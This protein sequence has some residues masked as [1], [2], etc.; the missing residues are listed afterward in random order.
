MD[1]SS[2]YQDSLQISS[3]TPLEQ[4]YAWEI[5]HKRYDH[6]PLMTVQE[7][8][9]VQDMFLSN[10]ERG[11]H[12]KNLYLRD[13]KNKN[14]LFIAEQ[15]TKIDLKK[16]GN[17]SGFANLLFGSPERLMQNLRVK[18]GA[19]TPLS[20]ITGVQNGVSLFIDSNFKNCSKIYVH[21]FVNDRTLEIPLTELENFLHIIKTGFDWVD[22]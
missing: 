10:K 20:M 13:K 11:G 19:V 16:L 15:D 5:Q 9:K 4:L 22:N 7:S 12:I 2:N 14:V 8:K 6:V 17:T 18:T 1:A 3:D 21:P